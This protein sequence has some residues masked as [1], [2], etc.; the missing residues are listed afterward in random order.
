MKV[1]LHS[2]R[3]GL[4]LGLLALLGVVLPMTAWAQAGPLPMLTSTP[5]ADG[6]QTYT[7]SIQTL[8][9]LTALTLSLIHI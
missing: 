5:G 7:L 1:D 2:S 4:W 3:P 8:L 9:T 6:S